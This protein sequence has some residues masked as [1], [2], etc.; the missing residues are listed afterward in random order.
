MHSLLVLA[1]IAAATSAV[2]VR[3]TDVQERETTATVQTWDAQGLRLSGS[4][5]DRSAFPLD[6]VLRVDS[7]TKPA[8]R[9]M[10]VGEV[11]LTDGARL[12]VDQFVASGTQ[13]S[14]AGT[15]IATA[16]Q[17]APLP[18]PLASVRA[19]RMMPLD[20]SVPTLETEWRD[21]LA[22]DP[23]GDLIVIRKPGAAN[24]NFVEGTLGDVNDQ[25]V[26][27]DLDGE[28]INVNRNKVFGIIY[29][30]RQTG[31][32][33]TPD[34][35][36]TGPGFKLPI[37][38]AALKNEQLE[39]RSPTLGT[40]T[41]PMSQ[42]SAVDY[43]LARL[44]YLSDLDLAQDDWAAAA[45]A[46]PRLGHIA[47]DR[48]FYDEDLTLAYPAQSLSADEAS[49]SGL[50]EIRV[51]S[52]GLALRGGSDAGFR[53]PRDFTTFRATAG[54][55]PRSPGSVELEMTIL[56]DG[57][58]LVTETLRGAAAP[59]ELECKVAGLR[60]ITIVVRSAGGA[61]WTRG[62]GDIVHLGGARFVK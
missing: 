54:V 2:E 23:A 35:V 22:G 28:V 25:A 4:D 57:K 6:A 17:G 14:M 49:S 20:P 32:A 43:S 36:V 33:D 61:S 27:F 29:F 3:V 13:C 62:M 53:V 34:A 16:Q 51:F 50:S 41:L 30:R 38:S 31:D 19:V 40:V 56:G 42:V 46:H 39:V 12:A 58:P 45:A 48:G 11:L 21:L 1:L 10:P 8:L 55:D 26:Q 52:K 47:R 7:T 44:Q 9:D 24:L 37:T 18:A 5:P 60:Q 15:P 59:I